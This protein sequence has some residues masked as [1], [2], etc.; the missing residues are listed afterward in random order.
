ML[1]EPL[2]SCIVLCP[3][4][5]VT[6]CSPASATMNIK[7]DDGKYKKCKGRIYIF[8]LVLVSLLKFDT[9]TVLNYNQVSVAI[10]DNLEPE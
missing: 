9:D 4:V 7:N 3:V 6:R 2:S 10:C 8:F 1:I 5:S